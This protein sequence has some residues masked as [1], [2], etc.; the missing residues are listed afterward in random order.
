[1]PLE[2][3]KVSP[4]AIG[5]VLMLLAMS[6]VSVGIM[7][8]R[9]WIY[10]RAARRSRRYA[11]ELAP[12]LR[13]G[14][15]RQA[16][17]VSAPASSGG[18]PLAQVIA[19]GLEDWERMAAGRG[20]GGADLALQTVSDTLRHTATA[21]EADLKRRLATL[22]TIGS[23]APF[24]GL[25]GT[26][27]GIIHAFQD[28]ARTGSTN[29]AVISGGIAEALYTTALG[30]VVAIPAVWAYNSL[31]SR[32]QAIGLELD[33]GATHLMRVL[34]VSAGAAEGE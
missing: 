9:W 19:A 20:F 26:T 5:V 7:T 21:V 13:L 28:I 25:F 2:L 30:L 8:E 1:M 15:L 22:A 24:V 33:R 29:M 32:V 27:F 6:V 10:R 12:L 16:M 31:G 14:R 18:S 17:Q 34:A 11:A 4:V 3:G 23:T